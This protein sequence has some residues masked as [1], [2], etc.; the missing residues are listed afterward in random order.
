LIRAS[1]QLINARTKYSANTFM[2]FGYAP[3]QGA[4]PDLQ[5][6][7]DEQYQRYCAYL[8]DQ[9]AHGVDL[10]G[11]DVL[12]VGCGRGGGSAFYMRQFEPRSVTGID[13]AAR[14]IEFCNRYYQL[15][16]LHFQVGDAEHLPF[17]PGSFDVV[18][19]VESSHCYP[20]IE[21]FFREAHRVLRP[22]GHLLLSDFRD[23]V[24][25]D[26]FRDQF[27][28]AGFNIIEDESITKNVIRALDLDSE[29][30]LKVV[31]QHSL[32]AMRHTILE[33]MGV[34]GSRIYT[35]FSSGL[36]DYRRFVAV[37]R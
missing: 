13:F 21:A 30:R 18:A 8:Y 27:V 28:A 5:L 9:A 1:Y 26:Q 12:E 4:E 17:E 25:F 6:N 10:K 16:G 11:C 29:R 31:Q 19:S 24:D 36:I 22:N 37:K 20:D 33:F 32:R 2:N 35:D 23:S 7:E 15:D 14:A 34:T 3:L